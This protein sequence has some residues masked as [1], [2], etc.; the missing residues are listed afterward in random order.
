MYWGSG[1]DLLHGRW[2]D[3]T[4]RTDIQLTRYLAMHQQVGYDPNM[5]VWRDL[6]SQYNW[7]QSDKLT[8]NVGTR[9]SLSGLGLTS[10]STELNW[11]VS[12][13]WRI[14][15]HGGYNGTTRQLLYD[16]F[17]FIR[18]MHCW[19]AAFLYQRATEPGL[20]LPSPESIELAVAEF[21]HRPRGAGVEYESGGAKLMPALK[22]AV[23]GGGSTYTPELVAGLMQH[24]LPVREVVLVD[25]DRQRLEIV[26]GLAQR[27]VAAT[28]GGFPV[29]LTAALGPALDGADFVV[30]QLRV[31]GQ[32]AR[33]QDE[34][35][36]LRYGL[37]GQ[38]TTGAGGFA[39]ALRTI[40][41]ILDINREMAA[42]ARPG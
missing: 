36:P 27:M 25:P 9:F 16:E 35:I 33:I 18:D 28:G 19:D 11:V 20:S 4:Y 39:K 6:V 5:S 37:I 14:E 21:Q 38:E 1:R 24:E 3:L 32:A 42:R 13:K 10:V 31:G 29:T 17:L 40:P 30:T 2:Q 12:S 41:V 8:F 7:Q 15:W 34:R 22:I 26:G 23:I